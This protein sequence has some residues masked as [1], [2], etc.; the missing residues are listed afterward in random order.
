M[1]CRMAHRQAFTLSWYGRVLMIVVPGKIGN[2]MLQI[3]FRE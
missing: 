3:R 1:G 2:S